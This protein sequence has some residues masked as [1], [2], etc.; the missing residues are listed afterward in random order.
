ML[1]LIIVTLVATILAIVL[2]VMLI[3][4]HYWGPQGPPK[5]SGQDKERRQK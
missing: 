3:R 2:Y 1:P 4:K 5:K